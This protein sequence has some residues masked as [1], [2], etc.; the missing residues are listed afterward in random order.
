MF[1]AM[2][3]ENM[4]AGRTLAL[5]MALLS[6]TGMVQ[7]VEPWQRPGDRTVML[8]VSKT[9]GGDAHRRQQPLALGLRW[10][11]SSTQFHRQVPLVDLRYSLDRKP[12]LMAGGVLMYDGSSSEENL[13][14]IRANP[15]LAALLIGA[16]VVGLACLTEVGICN[17]GSG[18]SEYRPPGG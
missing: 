13:S 17:G 6:A 7:A 9:I 1:I 12:M 10:Q 4:T 16:G 11:Q 3:D 5:G 15:V 14:S 2:E 18:E 8:Y